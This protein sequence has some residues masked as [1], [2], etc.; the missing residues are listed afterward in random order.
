MLNCDFGDFRLSVV[1]YH[2]RLKILC[3]TVMTVRFFLTNFEGENI[4]TIEQEKR[5]MTMRFGRDMDAV[6]IG[7]IRLGQEIYQ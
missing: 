5:R 2:P 7:R 4:I 1:V 6:C 3:V